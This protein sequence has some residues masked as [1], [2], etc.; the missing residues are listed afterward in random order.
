M[1][2]AWKLC[3]KKRL[4][5]ITRPENQVTWYESSHSEGLQHPH[6]HTRLGI[7]QYKDTLIERRLN[8]ATKLWISPRQNSA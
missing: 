5:P 2:Q 8:H 1:I 6:Q 3:K 7:Q 4:S